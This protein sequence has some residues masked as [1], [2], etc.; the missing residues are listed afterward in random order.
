MLEAIFVICVCFCLSRGTFKYDDQPKHQ[1][2]D[3]NHER[4]ANSYVCIINHYNPCYHETIIRIWITCKNMPLRKS[5]EFGM[6]LSA[7]CYKQNTKIFSITKPLNCCF[8]CFGFY[9]GEANLNW[10]TKQTKT[11][12][13]V[14]IM[15]KIKVI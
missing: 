2:V 5:I 3:N 15:I 7:T 9:K 6:T 12:K 8:F 1:K 13:F 11:T 10:K 4:Y 14:G